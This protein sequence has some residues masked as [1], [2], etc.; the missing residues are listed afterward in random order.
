MILIDYSQ[1]FI[2]AAL[3]FPKDFEKGCDPKKMI[4]ICRHT[5]LNTLLS[6]KAKFGEEFGEIVI[7]CDGNDYWRRAEFAQYKGKRKAGREES[8]TDWKA[9][10]EIGKQLRE[11]F[12]EVFPYKIVRVAEA[13]ADDVIAVLVKYLQENELNVT[14]L[15]Q[16]EPQNILIKSSDGDFR[17]LHKYKGVRQWNPLLKKYVAKPEKHFLLEKCLT[18]DP[19]DGV[20]N[21]RSRDNQ[22]MEGV[23]QQ[24]ITAKI[25]EAAFKQADAGEPITFDDVEMLRNYQ[26]N[27]KL[28]DFDFIP[29]KVAD[30]IIQAYTQAT[31]VH[32]KGKIFNYL[33]KHRCRLLLDKIQHF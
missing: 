14:G 10:F 1:T 9:V 29:K 24:P 25:K 8:K 5:T 31:Q 27:R 13:E 7:A 12:A 15:M 11:E 30:D 17:Q 2:G 26:R 4:D 23:R 28:I 21:V 22:L 3:S 18:G 33:T 16:E 19:G 32:N 6:D 20:P